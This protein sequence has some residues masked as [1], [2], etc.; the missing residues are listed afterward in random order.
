MRQDQL[1]LEKISTYRVLLRMLNNK[2][3]DEDTYH[4]MV[5]LVSRARNLDEVSVVFEKLQLSPF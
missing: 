5:D 4:E 3:I 1:L 2:D